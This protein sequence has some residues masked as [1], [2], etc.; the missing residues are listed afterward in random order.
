MGLEVEKRVG[1]TI[2]NKGKSL[3]S[4]PFASHVY[5]KCHRKLN[6][7]LCQFFNLAL[8]YSVN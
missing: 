5:I 2:M 7:L 8:P 6:V 1:Q 4:R 3:P